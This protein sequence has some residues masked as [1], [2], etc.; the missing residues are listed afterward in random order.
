MYQVKLSVFVLVGLFIV[1]GCAKND[2][3]GD[4]SET[5]MASSDESSYAAAAG[6][7][8]VEAHAM[9]AMEGDEPLVVSLLKA[10]ESGEGWSTKFTHLDDAIMSNNMFMMGDTIVSES[11]PFPSA[12]DA[13]A[14]V[15]N[16][17]TYYHFHGDGMAGRFVAT[18]AS[19]DVLHGT[20]S[21]E[22]VN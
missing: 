20:I 16:V 8:L 1:A 21:G 19:G 22:R 5:E 7:W 4:T 14:I 2:D 9:D 6:D 13:D 18:Y 3:Q 11:G 12:I 17:T 15:Q 10:T